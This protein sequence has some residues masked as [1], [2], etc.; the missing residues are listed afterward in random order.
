MNY[1]ELANQ[2]KADYYKVIASYPE[3]EEIFADSSWINE[4]IETNNNVN[5]IVQNLEKYHWL[6]AVYAEEDWVKGYWFSPV[7]Y[8]AIADDLFD[9]NQ[10]NI[11]IIQRHCSEIRAYEI[12]VY[13][14][15]SSIKMWNNVVTVLMT[16]VTI[17]SVLLYIN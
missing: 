15:H 13:N 14:L 3:M 9:I 5:S 17:L 12:T 16:I 4:M 1:T 8:E 11:S 10:N 2:I 6:V 7:D